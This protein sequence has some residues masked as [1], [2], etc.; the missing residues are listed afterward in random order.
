MICSSFVSLFTI[1]CV[2]IFLPQCYGR[3][4]HYPIGG[5][6]VR[7]TKLEDDNSE[8]QYYWKYLSVNF[9][10]AN[11]VVRRPNLED[12]YFNLR[13]Y[14]A[15]PSCSYTENDRIAASTCIVSRQM[16]PNTV[17]PSTQISV[18]IERELGGE[19]RWLSGM[20]RRIDSPSA[21]LVYTI[22]LPTALQ[23]R[24][25]ALVVKVLSTR[26]FPSKWSTFF[27]L[28]TNNLTW[29]NSK[30]TY[31]SLDSIMD[32]DGL[33]RLS[34]QTTTQVFS[35]KDLN[36]TTKDLVT[37]H[38][39]MRSQSGRFWTVFFNAPSV[40]EI[41]HS[42]QGTFDTNIVNSV[43][44]VNGGLWRNGS[45]S[46]KTLLA[47]VI[48]FSVLGLLIVVAILV[49][50]C[51]WKRRKTKMQKARTLPPVPLNAVFVQPSVTSTMV[52]SAVDL[53]GTHGANT[54]PGPMIIANVYPSPP[55]VVPPPPKVPDTMPETVHPP[56]EDVPVKKLGVR[57]GMGSK[58]DM[59]DDVPSIPGKD[60]IPAGKDVGKE[61]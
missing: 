29:S 21:W 14:I 3:E 17:D 11:V 42:W 19:R 30:K 43:V 48:S 18:K 10:I 31:K 23:S 12:A 39:I 27:K 60:A 49:A 15:P 46:L 8:D 41:E 20:R 53:V 57:L 35:E 26:T 28:G 7:F 55:P 58:V 56:V 50:I 36:P 6:S 32:L 33:L 4:P 5:S 34:L 2:Y 37:S 54:Q 9:E 13:N 59:P 44:D 47:L 52:S 38:S 25:A 24:D 61:V 51:V 1:L 45:M 22:K 16:D 40:I